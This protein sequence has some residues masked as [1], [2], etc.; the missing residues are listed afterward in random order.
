MTQAAIKNHLENYGAKLTSDRFGLKDSAYAFDGNTSHL[1][2]DIEDRKGDFSLSL[3]AKADD[4]EQSRFRSVINI[5]DKPLGPKTL[6]KFI[7]VAAVTLLINS[8]QAK[9]GELCTSHKK[10]ATPRRFC[11]R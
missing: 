8:F 7:P 1:F 10:L 4:V 9:S 11:F 2:T 6:V 5:H 3:W